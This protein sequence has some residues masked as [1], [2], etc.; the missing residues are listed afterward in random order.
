MVLFASIAFI[1]P[2]CLPFEIRDE[3]FTNSLVTVVG[4][5]ATDYGKI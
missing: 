5:G 1:R 2:A 3:N 4:W